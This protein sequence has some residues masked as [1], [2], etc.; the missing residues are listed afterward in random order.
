[1]LSCTVLSVCYPSCLPRK[2]WSEKWVWSSG[3]SSSSKAGKWEKKILEGSAGHSPSSLAVLPAAWQDN[4]RGNRAGIKIRNHSFFLSFKPNNGK[5]FY[6][7]KHKKAPLPP[8][9]LP[10]LHNLCPVEGTSLGRRQPCSC[11]CQV[12]ESFLQPTFI[13]CRF[14]C[15]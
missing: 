12:G 15:H 4:V 6:Q 10:S 2:S 5:S 13:V 11:P 9:T 14:L 8:P 1:M 3:N 7:L